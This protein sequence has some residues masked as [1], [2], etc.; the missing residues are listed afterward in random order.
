VLLPLYFIAV[1]KGMEKDLSSSVH[2]DSAKRKKRSSV[3]E[4]EISHFI[5]NSRI[6]AR[7]PRV[8]RDGKV[9][10]IY[11]P[12]HG[13]GWYSEH[14]IEALLFSPEIVNMIEQEESG[15]K[16]YEYCCKTN[17]GWSVM[18]TICYGLSIKWVPVSE[19]FRIHESN[20]RETVVLKSTDQ[21]FI[22]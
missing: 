13:L 22:A 19:E 11:Q 4:M 1:I 12:H 17:Y 18:D 21:W 7:A 6:I 10:V 2:I 14:K 5:S 16:I 8:T 3:Q 20:G 9:A 15:S